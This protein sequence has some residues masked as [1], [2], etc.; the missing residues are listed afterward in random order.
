MGRMAQHNLAARSLRHMRFARRMVAGQPLLAHALTGNHFHAT[1]YVSLHGHQL[2]VGRIV[3]RLPLNDELWMAD[4]TL[5]TN[6]TSDEAMTP[7]AETMLRLLPRLP[8]ADTPAATGIDSSTHPAAS[9]TPPTTEITT[10]SLPDRARETAPDTQS[11]PPTA[12]ALTVT[13]VATDAPAMRA[14]GPRPRSRIVELPGVVAAPGTDDTG[15]DTAPADTQTKAQTK[16]ASDTSAEQIEQLPMPDTDEQPTTANTVDSGMASPPA[17]DSTP[18]LA[19]PATRRRGGK[20]A[21]ATAPRA[22]DAL[23]PPTDT[24]RSPAAWLARLRQEAQPTPPT[25]PA[26][27]DDES[28]PS[29]ERRPV[30]RQTRK[31]G[32]TPKSS[33]VSATQVTGRS[34]TRTLQAPTAAEKPAA[35]P[36]SSRTLL[37]TLTGVDPASA[38]IYRGP[39][40]ERATSAQNADALTD[41]SA[42]ALGAG[43]ATDTPETLGLLAHELTHVAQRRSPRF[44]PPVAHTSP[45]QPLSATSIASRVDEEALAAQVEAR[46]TNIARAQM[47]APVAVQP[48]LP[49][50]SFQPQP[51]REQPSHVETR[52]I[53]GN[54]PAPWEPLPD[55]MV[56]PADAP[57]RAPQ[58]AP[59]P[60]E[61]P[62]AQPPSSPTATRSSS[63]EAQGIQRAERGRSLP[64]ETETSPAVSAREGGAPEP[65]LD[66]LAQQVHAILKRRLAAEQRRFG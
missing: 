21:S 7:T 27:S 36:D 49:A 6:L 57:M 22:S 39:Q 8:E 17:S 44:I 61:R 55:W 29:Q 1:A 24:D 34:F 53:W 35:L 10:E 48:I 18:V 64:A 52:P 65:D 33:A 14:N 59:H 16:G 40:A 46:V 51:A 42:I 43:H 5:D 15:D 11:I 50:P 30:E 58:A 13:T 62:A 23:F 12:P 28:P 60:S 47:A 32:Q 20:R 31:G 19:T 54:L 41:G 4:A 63:A 56:A 2:P 37:H 66:A 3:R 9:Q 25:T 45:E 26:R 38:H